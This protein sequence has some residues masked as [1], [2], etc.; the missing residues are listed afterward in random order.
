LSNLAQHLKIET[1][2]TALHRALYD[3]DVLVDV[4]NSFMQKNEP[5][6]MQ[7]SLLI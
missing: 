5:K 1:Q 2:K 6:E 3:V 4:L 7:Y